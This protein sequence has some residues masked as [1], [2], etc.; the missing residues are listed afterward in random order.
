MGELD[1]PTACLECHSE[2]E[3]EATH[4]HPLE[5]IEACQMCHTLHGSP[6]PGL[7]K[8]PVKPLCKGCHDT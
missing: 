4:A 3:F 8:G 7:L 1:T 2:V 6:H 5:P